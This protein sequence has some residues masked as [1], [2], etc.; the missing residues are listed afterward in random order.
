VT[1]SMSVVEQPL[2]FGVSTFEPDSDQPRSFSRTFE[3]TEIAPDESGLPGIFLA[4]ATD[5][6][7]DGTLDRSRR[8][9]DALEQAVRRPT[10]QDPTALLR[11]GFRE[12]NS[13]VFAMAPGDV[14]VVALLARSKYATFASS[15]DNHAFLF[16][17]NRLNKVTRDQYLLRGR[18]RRD[19]PAE[20]SA[21]QDA[22]RSA[23]LF[24]G[25][26]VRLENR[27]PA[28]YD[29]V[30]LPEDLVLLATQSAT[31]A[32]ENQ[33]MPIATGVELLS[34]LD[35][36]VRHFES[37]TRAAIL[38]EVHPSRERRPVAPPAPQPRISM[39]PLVVLFMIIV[40]T[41]AIVAFFFV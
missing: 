15:G 20:S 31:V 21:A 6:T 22:S 1:A 30:L 3:F 39:I 38:L 27:L 33:V 5:H 28:F 29:I 16:R 23:P 40:A 26:Q 19:V 35:A 10:E 2:K 7:D 9:I 13:A 41:I 37:E 17:A 11:Q 34:V 24:L 8:A 32:L 18:S 12:A 14:S 36:Q 4:I 25:R